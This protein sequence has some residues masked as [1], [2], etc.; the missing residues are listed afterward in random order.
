MNTEKQAMS[1]SEF[2]RVHSISRGLFYQL[3]KRGNGPAI[4][5]AGRRRLIT[6]EAALAWR[7]RMSFQKQRGGKDSDESDG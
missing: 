4:L 5:K 2:C 7:E 6:S 1:V 3:L